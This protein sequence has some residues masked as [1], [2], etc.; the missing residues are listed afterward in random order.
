MLY[1]YLHVGTYR[2][3]EAFTFY[4]DWAIVLKMVSF[5]MAWHMSLFFKAARGPQRAALYLSYWYSRDIELLLG[6][7]TN[8]RDDHLG[9]TLK[10]VFVKMNKNDFCIFFKVYKRSDLEH[11]I[12]FLSKT[13]QILR[14]IILCYKNRGNL[15]D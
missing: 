8:R 15:N 11:C 12:L 7:Y 14:N 1:C 10:E 3:R 2:P 9:Q 4:T 6:T 5:K 13:L